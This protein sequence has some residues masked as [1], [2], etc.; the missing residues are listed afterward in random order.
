MEKL[1]RGKQA[2][3][4]ANERRG[5]VS[6]GALVRRIFQPRRG[7][8]QAPKRGEGQAG[9]GS[10]LR[11]V[12]DEGVGDKANQ[13]H[14]W[15]KALEKSVDQEVHGALQHDA[16]VQVPPRVV[17]RSWHLSE[18][19]GASEGHE[20]DSVPA[21]GGSCVQDL[22]EVF[23]GGWATDQ[24][25]MGRQ[26]GKEAAK[27]RG[28]P[29]TLEGPRGKEDFAAVFCAGLRRGQHELLLETRFCRFLHKLETVEDQ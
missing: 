10:R 3:P 13:G 18:R 1:G 11:R 26:G 7:V 6:G 5:Q 15:E 17:P 27:I 16:A 4:L 20:R 2:P 21:R 8:H 23:Q 14:Q 25:V 22:G 28:R 24:G 9:V 19:F 12:E 29:E